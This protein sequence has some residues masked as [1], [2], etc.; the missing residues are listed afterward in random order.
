MQPLLQAKLWGMAAPAPTSQLPQ[1]QTQLQQ[2]P[3]PEVTEL[4][5]SGAAA[6]STSSDL[7]ALYSMWASRG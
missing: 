5:A 3:P 4:T 7:L 1:L 6:A 2:L